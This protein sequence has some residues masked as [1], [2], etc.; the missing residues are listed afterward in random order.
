MMMSGQR[1]PF[2]TRFTVGCDSSGR[3]QAVKADVFCNGG[4]SLDISTGVLE[5]AVAH[6]D[7]IYD[8]PNVSIR[9]RICKTNTV[10]NT[11]FRGF[12]GP[13]GMVIGD[14]ILHTIADGLKLSFD[15]LLLLNMYK[16]GDRTPYGQ[17]VVD[18]HVPRLIQEVQL[19]SHYA[20]RQKAVKAWNAHH[21]WRKR[22]ICTTGVKFGLAFGIAFLNQASALVHLHMDGSVL[23]QHG[24]TEMGQGELIS[25]RL[26]KSVLTL[27]LFCR[28]LYQDATGCSTG[29]W[30]PSRDVPHF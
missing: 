28:S 24:G 19:K 22:G 4:Y 1:H 13:Q 18:W 8:F 20:E 5:R 6:L 2:L 14:S 12:G 21:K 11:A 30:R 23:V 3:V 15:D 29:A 10:S 25:D 16:E 27:A 26:Q 17:P 7:N 9:G